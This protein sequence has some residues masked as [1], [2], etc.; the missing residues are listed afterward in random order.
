MPPGF[1]VNHVNQTMHMDFGDEPAGIPRE[2]SECNSNPA[3]LPLN[4][5][6]LLMHNFLRTQKSHSLL[7]HTHS[8]RLLLICGGCTVGG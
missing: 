2:H 7:A 6:L 8:G 1:E 5:N 4:A 3:S